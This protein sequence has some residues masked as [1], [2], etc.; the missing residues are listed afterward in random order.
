MYCIVDQA[1]PSHFTQGRKNLK[2]FLQTKLCR[3]SKQN[4]VIVDQT[5]VL[6]QN[7]HHI[8]AVQANLSSPTKGKTNLS[9]LKAD[10]TKFL[11]SKQI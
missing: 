9:Y 10:Q 6:Q 4:Y 3:P 2:L 5:V 8:N 7:K 11:Q 1:N